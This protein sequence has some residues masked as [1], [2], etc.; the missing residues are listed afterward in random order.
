MTP[1]L[2]KIGELTAT[3]S[4]SSPD[5]DYVSIDSVTSTLIVSPTLAQVTSG[6]A[7]TIQHRLAYFDGTTTRVMDYP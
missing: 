6:E 3:W 2:Q 7:T 5:L 1:K 4:L